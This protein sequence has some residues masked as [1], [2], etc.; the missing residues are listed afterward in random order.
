MFDML[1]LVVAL[2]KRTS[3]SEQVT[4]EWFVGICGGNP[5]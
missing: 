1:Q 2:Q 4:A 3:Y 5:I